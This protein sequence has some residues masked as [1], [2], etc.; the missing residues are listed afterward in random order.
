[1]TDPIK[2]TCSCCG[3]EH[4]E[5]PALTYNSP[6]PYDLLSDEDKKNI[7][8]L[9]SDFCVIRHPE[10]IDRFI[11]G[12]LTQKVVDHCE[13][14][15]YGLW[16]SLSEKSFQ[17]YF[18]NFKNENHETKYF[19][20]LSSDLPDYDFKESI[21]TTVYTLTGNQRPEIVP[22]EDHEHPFVRDYYNGITKV[23]AERRIKEMLEGIDERE[24]H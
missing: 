21:P 15:D 14:L 6:T 10:Q 7:A 11:R 19:G 2:Y 8:E 1:M 17:D 12:T 9:D 20:W 24:K 16:V 23:E 18:D 4:E 22:H 13:N 3:Q 5:W